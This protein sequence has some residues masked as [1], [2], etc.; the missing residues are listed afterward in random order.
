MYT[1]KIRKRFRLFPR[2]RVV[3]QH[4]FV[5]GWLKLVGEN[6]V[7]FIKDVT[8]RSVFLYPDY[9]A[10]LRAKRE[11]E[12]FELRQEAEH[13]RQVEAAR[14]EKV[15]APQVNPVARAAP[16]SEESR[17][18]WEQRYNQVAYERAMEKVNAL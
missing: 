16:V 12:A 18:G 5:D 10:H 8:I 3:A 2:K 13:M 1:I 9:Y 15:S 11:R 6:G 7:E 17:T 14:V 4:E